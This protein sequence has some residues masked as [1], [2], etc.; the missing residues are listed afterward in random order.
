VDRGHPASQCVERDLRPPGVPA[1]DLRVQTAAVRG[2]DQRRL[3]RVTDRFP[4]TLGVADQVGVVAQDQVTGEPQQVLAVSVAVRHRPFRGVSL[5]GEG[6]RGHLELA[7]LGWVHWFNQARL[8]S[9]IGHVPPIEYEN[10]YYRHIDPQQQPLPGE[11]S[12][13]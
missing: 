7:T 3:H 13:H 12:L 6:V 5:A 9:S 1:A 10:A 2:G 11:P 8:H 4:G